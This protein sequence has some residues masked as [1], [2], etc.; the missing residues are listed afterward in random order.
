MNISI[1]I[2]YW[3][4]EKQIELMF[5]SLAEQMPLDVE[6]E[7]L[8]CDSHSGGE[9]EEIISHARKIYPCLN[10]RHLHCENIVAQK[11]NVG[12]R[13]A[14]H[15]LLIFLDDDCVPQ[16]DYLKNVFFDVEK[17]PGDILCGE[18]RFPINM[19]NDSNYYRYR[20]SKHPTFSSRPFRELDQWSFVSMNMVAKKSDLMQAGLSYDERF[21]GYGCEDHEF[22]WRILKAGLNIKMGRFC[23]DHHEYDGDIVKYKRKIFCTAR[24]GMYMLSCLAP[25]IVLS[26][27]KLSMI[28]TVYSGK[29]FPAILA[30]VI[31]SVLFN[32]YFCRT[33]ESFLQKTD[34]KIN[35]YFPRAY[36]Y[37]LL[38]NYLAGVGSR[39]HRLTEANIG[40]G[41]YD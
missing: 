20:D 39:E 18:I 29:K 14:R 35:F 13:E 31:L 6:A 19:V 27:R 41:W 21:I 12:M 8:V 16:A 40:A 23:I 22:P 7:V 36:R 10:I 1:I 24:D 25:E 3:K 11:R 37:V 9:I 30:R 4:R 34:K 38:C 32:R 2:P 33:I 28:E 17:Y 26:H 5:S 15:E